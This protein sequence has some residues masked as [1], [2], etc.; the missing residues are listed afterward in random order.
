MNYSNK[1]SSQIAIQ[2]IILSSNSLLSLK[3]ILP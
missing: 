2:V 3:G 1:I